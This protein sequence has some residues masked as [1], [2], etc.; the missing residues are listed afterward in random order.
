MVKCN[1][2]KKK[3]YDTRLEAVLYSKE[4]RIGDVRAHRLLFVF[5]REPFSYC[6]T[7]PADG[8]EGEEQEGEEEEEE[9]EEEGEGDGCISCCICQPPIVVKPPSHHISRSSVNAAAFFP[10]SPQTA[11]L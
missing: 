9:E 10:Q 7:V 1:R 6:N 11:G 3:V 4:R 8:D 5:K 2:K